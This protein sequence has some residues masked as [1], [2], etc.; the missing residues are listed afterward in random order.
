MQLRGAFVFLPNADFR[1]IAKRFAHA[2]L[3]E[4][5]RNDDG[6]ARSRN[7]ESEEAFAGPPADTREV[8][9]RGTGTDQ[10]GFKFWVRLRH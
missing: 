5:R 10:Q 1:R 6:I 7:D 3:F 4:G 2:C 9:E 8:D